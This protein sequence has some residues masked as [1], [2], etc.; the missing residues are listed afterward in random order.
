VHTYVEAGERRMTPC[1]EA[2]LTERAAEAILD[3]GL[4]PLLSRREANSARLA[5]FQSV[6]DPPAAL[7][8]PWS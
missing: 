3:R 8:G 1:A 7:S 4:M 6:A 5:R 2:F